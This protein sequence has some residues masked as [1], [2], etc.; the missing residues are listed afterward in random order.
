MTASTPTSSCCLTEWTK[1]PKVTYRIIKTIFQQPISDI[2]DTM[3]QWTS[4]RFWSNLIIVIGRTEYDEEKINAKFDGQIDG[5]HFSPYNTEEMTKSVKN[6]IL[7]AARYRYWSIE[8][9][10]GDSELLQEKHL[11]NMKAMEYTIKF[12]VLA[13]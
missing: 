9:E 6:I 3:H 4:G 1:A 10:N 12:R 11:S 2:L 13:D 5:K 7:K 8:L